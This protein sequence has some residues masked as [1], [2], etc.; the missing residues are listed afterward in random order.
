VSEIEGQLKQ[1]VDRVQAVCSR[2]DRDPARICIV[3]ATKTQSAEKI[4]EYIRAATKLGIGAAIGE[5]YLQEFIPKASHLPAV[6][7]HFIGALQSNKAKDIAQYFE[8]VEGVTSENGYRALVKEIA[9]TG[10]RLRILLQVNISNDD[11]KNGLTPAQTETLAATILSESKIELCGLMTIIKE[12]DAPSG[13]RP[14]YRALATLLKKIQ[15]DNPDRAHSCTELSM[16]MSSDFEV[17]IE[18]GATIIRVGAA[19]FGARN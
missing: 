6:E 16:G 3:A 12:Y 18:E 14:D 17:A 4:T 7:R 11:A 5:N 15:A 10:K 19:I 13:A 1:V 9:K 8:V 2:C